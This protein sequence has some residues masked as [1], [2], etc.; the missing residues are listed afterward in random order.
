MNK[1]ICVPVVSGRTVIVAEVSPTEPIAMKVAATIRDNMSIAKSQK[2]N[3]LGSRNFRHPSA[4]GWN[5][6]AGRTFPILPGD[7]K[8]QR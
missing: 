2:T 3:M 5:S 7:L 4:S 8:A 6:G 1:V